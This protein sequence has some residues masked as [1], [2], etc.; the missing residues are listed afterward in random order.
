MLSSFSY[1]DKPGNLWG[2]MFPCKLYNHSIFILQHPLLYHQ[3]SLCV[4]IPLF[5]FLP[6]L[7]S[8]LYNLP[9]ILYISR[10]LTIS[11]FVPVQR[12][13]G[14]EYVPS[15]CVLCIFYNIYFIKFQTYRSIEMIQLHIMSD[16]WR[17][18]YLTFLFSSEL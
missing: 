3:K 2:Q 5:L 14:S 4:Y 9:L 7:H 12:I 16:T 13:Q 15:D 1:I 17:L 11:L 6:K 18:S 8:N 10:L